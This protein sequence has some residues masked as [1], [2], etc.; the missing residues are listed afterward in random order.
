MY[1]QTAIFKIV[2]GNITSSRQDFKELYGEVV[3]DLI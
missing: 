3:P 2:S 1:N